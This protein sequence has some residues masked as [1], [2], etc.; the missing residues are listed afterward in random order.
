M[1]S[2]LSISSMNDSPVDVG[3]DATAILALRVYL[4]RESEDPMEVLSS[5]LLRGMVSLSYN[6]KTQKIIA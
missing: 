3:D 4:F 6:W 5:R 1:A 2:S